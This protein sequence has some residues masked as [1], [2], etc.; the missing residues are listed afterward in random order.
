MPGAT[1][2]DA[3]TTAARPALRDGFPGLDAPYARSVV[4]RPPAPP[5]C[6]EVLA[7]IATAVGIEAIA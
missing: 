6:A 5:S 3:Q 2:T 7:M 1:L 4:P